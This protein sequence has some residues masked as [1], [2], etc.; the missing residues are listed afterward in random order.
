MTLTKLGQTAFNVIFGGGE[1]NLNS[2]KTYIDWEGNSRSFNYGMVYSIVTPNDWVSGRYWV[3]GTGLLSTQD[4]YVY[5]LANPNGSLAISGDTNSTVG[6][7][8]STAHL[9]INNDTDSPITYT[10]IGIF[11]DASNQGWSRWLIKY[12]ELTAPVTIPANSSRTI[13]ITFNTA[14]V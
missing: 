14:N 10:H 8:Y 4:G 6:D 13:D 1:N 2:D 7:N 3:A 11:S 5:A 12:H 9:T